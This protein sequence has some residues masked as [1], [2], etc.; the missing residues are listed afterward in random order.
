MQTQLFI[1]PGPGGWVRATIEGDAD[2]GSCFVHFR[3]EANRWHA[4][5]VFATADSIASMPSPRRVEIA[6]NANDALST[7]LEA[8]LR[9]ADMPGTLEFHQAFATYPVPVVEPP[10]A[11]KRPKT[12]RLDDDW[13]AKVAETYR[14]AAARGLNPRATIAAAASVS[15]DVAGRWVY[16]ARKR[17]LLP[18][19]A[20]GKVGF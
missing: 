9:E 15:T 3:R 14:A 20:P 2:G 10:L 11:L 1:A 12:K 7:Q 5:Y 4:T 19:T 16:E 6:L 8:R 18:P 17:G 13:Y